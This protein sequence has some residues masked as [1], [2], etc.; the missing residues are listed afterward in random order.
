MHIPGIHSFGAMA[1][2]LAAGCFKWAI[3][4]YD[5]FSV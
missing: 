5:R 1:E 4:Q 2:W 3:N